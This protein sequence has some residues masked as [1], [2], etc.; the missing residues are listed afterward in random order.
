MRFTPVVETADAAGCLPGAAVST[1][2]VEAGETSII[3]ALLSMK[4]VSSTFHYVACDGAVV[5]GVA[6]N[7]LL[8]MFTFYVRA[9][10]TPHTHTII[11]N[12]TD[13]FFSFLARWWCGGCDLQN[14]SLAILTFF[15]RKYL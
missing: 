14:I 9:P 12:N 1:L 6:L 10:P 3:T 4:L 13:L 15:C 7:R 11:T 5:Q 8:V 2:T